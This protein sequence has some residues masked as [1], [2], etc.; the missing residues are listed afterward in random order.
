[1]MEVIHH[2]LVKSDEESPG[3][4]DLLE[5]LC[6]NQCHYLTEVLLLADL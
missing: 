3:E 6:Q 1:M 4:M 5:R 2:F